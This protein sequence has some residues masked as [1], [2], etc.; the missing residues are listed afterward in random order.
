M[1]ETLFELE[2]YNNPADEPFA[3]DRHERFAR[4][5]A[6][7][8][9][10][11]ATDAYLKA[12]EVENK[13]AASAN[14]CR[15]LRNPAMQRRIKFLRSEMLLQLGIDQFSIAV[16]R[17]S[18]AEGIAPG[19]ARGKISASERLTA[20]RDLEKGL[21][22]AQPDKIS[23][24]TQLDLSPALGTLRITDPASLTALVEAARAE[25]TQ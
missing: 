6:G 13:D 14:A 8:C 7:E 2:H 3:N 9:F 24:D 10:G 15:L 19:L 11:N 22:L 4:F 5:F 18:I 1:E 16:L 20:V 17:K 23:L 21:G 12:Y 25:V